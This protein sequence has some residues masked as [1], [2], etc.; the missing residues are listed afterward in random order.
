MTDERK[1]TIKQI[2]FIEKLGGKIPEDATLKEASILIRRLLNE[3][4]GQ[5]EKASED[6]T[7][8]VFD[9]SFEEFCRV[10]ENYIKKFDRS[11]S[12]RYKDITTPGR[13]KEFFKKSYFYIAYNGGFI[14][15]SKPSI[16]TRFCYGYGSDGITNE[17]ERI[18]A[19]HCAAL[20]RSDQDWFINEN[21][22][23]SDILNR[24]E[25]FKK[26]DALISKEPTGD[27]KLFIFWNRSSYW[28][29]DRE[30]IEIPE[31]LNKLLINAYSWILEDFKK[32]L[33][34]YLKRYGLKSVHSWSY[35]VD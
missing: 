25:E 30:Y 10:N 13:G 7:K 33:N 8:N 28:E 32:R 5:E 19:S 23:Q 15:I 22:Q 6:K 24:I 27:Q 34:T 16:E 1:A 12:T 29:Q 20:A 35:L 18:S 14:K 26:H 11:Y 4:K 9:E 2:A 31:D 3:Q 21:I 17:E